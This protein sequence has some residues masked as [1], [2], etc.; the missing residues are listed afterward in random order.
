MTIGDEPCSSGADNDIGAINAGG[1]RKRMEPS[2]TEDAVRLTRLS[3]HVAL[4]ELN[5]PAKRNA[6]NGAMAAGL[7]RAAQ[8]VESD[9]DIRVAIFGQRRRRLFR[10]RRSQ[11]RRGRPHRGIVR[12][13]GRLCRL[14]QAEAHKALDRRGQ[15]IRFGGGL[16]IM[17][18]CDIMIASEH[19]TFGLP[20]VKRG[21]L[22]TAGGLFRLPRAVPPAIAY[23]MVTTGEA[24]SADAALAYGLISAKVPHDQLLD[25][26][27]ALAE[28]IAGNAPLAV[29]ANSN[30]RGRPMTCPKRRSGGIRKRRRPEYCKP[31][32]FAKAPRPLSR[33]ARRCGGGGENYMSV[34]K[35][36]R[37]APLSA[38]VGVM[39]RGKLFAL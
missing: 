10:R 19:A 24:I 32:T 38:P 31:K 36:V 6:F 4:V 13:R 17:L 20:E 2:E 11:C 9:P 29:Q 5:R 14:R 30:L 15:R 18:S 37:T 28:T 3:A 35:H 23:R 1:G 16:E 22:A 25:A 21:L 7:A 33:S 39:N 34:Q 8:S 12:R 27:R 26:A